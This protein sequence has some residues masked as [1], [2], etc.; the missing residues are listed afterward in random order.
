MRND[1]IVEKMISYTEKI[2]GY[3]ADCTSFE[4][5]NGNHL[6]IEACVFNLSQLGELA[7]K[8][9]DEFKAAH[10]NIPWRKIYNLRNRI[11]HDYEGVNFSLVWDIVKEDL[12][13]LLEQF[14]TI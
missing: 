10:V 5:F 6:L 12:P 9:D 1:I 7:N 13:Q 11:V 3:C 14:K 2:L 4:E 8:V